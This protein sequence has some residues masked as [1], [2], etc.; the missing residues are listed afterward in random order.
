MA[1]ARTVSVSLCS[2]P[3]ALLLALPSRLPRNS[4]T[5]PLGFGFP[6]LKISWERKGK[7][8]GLYLYKYHIKSFVRKTSA[9]FYGDHTG[10]GNTWNKKMYKTF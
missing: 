6:F 5:K 1:A 8:L 2:L 4:C 7:L 9:P 3:G 10:L